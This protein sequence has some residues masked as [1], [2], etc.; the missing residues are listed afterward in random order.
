MHTTEDAL[1][2]YALER[3]DGEDRDAI[4]TDLLVCEKTAA[5]S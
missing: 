3:S 1:G 2:L 5:K 4:E